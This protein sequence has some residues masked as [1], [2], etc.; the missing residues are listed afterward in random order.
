MYPHAN[1]SVR[2]SIPA[3]L[4]VVA[5]VG[6]PNAGKSTLFNRLLGERR[7]IVDEQPGVTRDRNIAVARMGEREVLLVDTG[8]I[9]DRASSDVA[10]AVQEQT[11][12]AAQ[13]ADVV[14]A[15]FDGREGLNPL[16]QELVRR[17]R[18]LLKPVVYAVNKLDDQKLDCNTAEFFA[19][20]PGAVFPISAAHGRGLDAL[21]E[22]IESLLP[23]TRAVAEQPPG[24]QEQAI[25]VAIV[26]R[27]NVGKSS[28]LNAILG[29]ERAIVDDHPGTTRDAIDSTVE[30]DGQLYLLIDTAGIRRRP[31]VREIVER[32]SV[33]RAFRAV[34][35]AQVVLLLMDAVE[36]M[37]DQDAR[38]ANHVIE[39]GKAL[40]L[41]FNK[42][43]AVA[44]PARVAERYQQRLASEYATLADF[45]L[46]FISARTGE[47]IEKLFSLVRLLYQ[48]AQK[49]PAT[50][51][52]NACLVAAT[53]A[54]P[55]PAVHGKPLRFYYVVQTGVMPPTLA[56]FANYPESVPQPYKRYLETQFRLAFKWFGVPVRIEFRARP[57]RRDAQRIPASR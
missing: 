6:R 9:D 56:I 7:A 33:V 25:A 16:D 20:G 8:G 52:L 48:R 41:V 40:A 35:R 46:A 38:I 14:V 31:K 26:G 23:E 49:R 53:R 24:A 54:R 2:E 13:E 39:R 43:D 42:W 51:K 36:G 4:P 19:L 50:A 28:L 55:A 44:P 27:P 15:L 21:V 3:E 32:A 17:L 18:T 47:G 29:Y 22:H 37:T 1:L 12:L 34:D 5:I 45:P 57:R 10:K 30:R 11:W